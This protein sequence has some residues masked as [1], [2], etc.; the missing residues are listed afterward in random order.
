M[1][2]AGTAQCGIPNWRAALSVDDLGFSDPLPSSV[3]VAVIGA[4]LTGLSTAYHVLAERPGARVVVL[5]AEHI[6][7][8]ASSRST[9]MLTPG[10]G[11]DFGALVRRFGVEPA[12]SMYLRSLEA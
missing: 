1:L 2:T 4:G 5:E 3:D 10:V 11:Q 7:H 6:G 12:K 9:G 8:G